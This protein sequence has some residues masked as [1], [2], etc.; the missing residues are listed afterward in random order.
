MRPY[1]L[2]TNS[3]G[4]YLVSFSNKETGK[5][6]PYK[7]THTKDYSEAITIAMKWFTDGVPSENVIRAKRTKETECKLNLENLLGRLSKI[8][9]KTLYEMIGSK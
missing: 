2:T 1:Y 4:Y 8:E 6:T 3:F 5:R 7:S 9:A